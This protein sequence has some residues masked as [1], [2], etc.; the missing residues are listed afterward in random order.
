MDATIVLADDHEVM[1]DGLRA[2]LEKSGE[3]TVVGEAET[4]R[5]A[6]RLARELK[7]GIVV[8]DINMPDLN[9][10]EATRQIKAEFPDVKVVV[11][12]MHTERRFVTA[13]LEAGASAYV[14]KSSAFKEVAEAINAVQVGRIYTSPKVTD[15]VMDDY[16]RQLA[17]SET[18]AAL[19]SPLTPRERE[20]L[21]LL[22]EGNSSKQ[23]ADA[24][25]ISVNTVDT[26]RHRIMEKL[27]LHS[28]A[29]L[30]KYAIRE[31]ITSLDG[32]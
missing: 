14:L 10:I 2:F 21:Q 32:S 30:T 27:D 19:S 28:A 5:Q 8:M 31:G 23:I 25:N 9:G 13:M 12:S 3:Y 18:A 22:A 20:V 29:E 15:L 1:R 16:I 11:L 17:K 24:L 7:P 26:H 6:L 4:G